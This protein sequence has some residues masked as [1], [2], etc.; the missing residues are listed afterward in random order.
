MSGKLDLASLPPEIRQKVE[1][2]LAKLSPDVRRQWE[3]QGSPMLD[4]LVTRLAGKLATN[5]AP[6]AL[7]AAL[8][9]RIPGAIA[10]AAALRPGGGTVSSAR[11]LPPSPPSVIQRTPPRGHY[12]DT[13]APGDRPGGLQRVLLGLVV[14]GVIFWLLR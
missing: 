1:A 14:A 9:E 7:P 2:G 8:S 4:R 11:D 3:A 13:V 6:P 10:T 12:N 5:R